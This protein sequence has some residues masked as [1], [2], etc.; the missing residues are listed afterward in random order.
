MVTCGSLAFA[1]ALQ[2]TT[3]RGV[4]RVPAFEDRHR[5]GR[6]SGLGMTAFPP[7]LHAGFPD[8]TLVLL[9]GLASEHPL[10]GLSKDRPSVVSTTGKSTPGALPTANRGGR[11]FGT[12]E[13]P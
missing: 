10:L 6:P 3:R 7:D 4:P 11:S 12:R 2:D 1:A 8:A 5:R 13:P 9:L